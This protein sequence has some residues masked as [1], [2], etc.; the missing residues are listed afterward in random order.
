M[1]T[2][3]AKQYEVPNIEATT[4][5]GRKVFKPEKW[6]KRFRQHTKQK[7]KTDITEFIWEAE[8]TL[9]MEVSARKHYFE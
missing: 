4:N 8:K 1:T 7:H 2:Q 3:L 6:L 5:N 9:Q